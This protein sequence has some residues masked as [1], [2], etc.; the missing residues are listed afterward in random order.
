[1]ELS[2]PWD[3]AVTGDAEKVTP[4]NSDEWADFWGAI[5]TSGDTGDEDRGVLRNYL[6]ELEVIGATLPVTM[7]SGG[8]LVRG[9]L[10][11]NDDP[12]RFY[13]GLPTTATRTDR[14]VLRSSWSAQTIRAVL[15]ENAS[16]GTGTPPALTQS[17]GVTWE[18][19]IAT[20][21]VTTGGDVTVTDNRSWIHVGHH[22]QR[23]EFVRAMGGY[24][25]TN[26]T[27]LTPGDRDGVLLVDGTRSSAYS[28]WAVP[29]DYVKDLR[30]E[31]ILV[32]TA[33]VTGGTGN[34]YGEITVVHTACGENPNDGSDPITTDSGLQ[35]MIVT[36]NDLGELFVPISIWVPNAAVGDIIQ[37]WFWRFDEYGD[38][39]LVGDVRCMGFRITYT[40]D[41]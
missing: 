41:Y 38:G 19:P 9:R 12:V 21:A 37:L 35:T 31:P 40:S 13:V 3:G 10:Y 24:D 1:V 2:V 11:L 4:I 8:A 33:N 6:N 30:V 17:L 7:K 36:T 14:I 27:A 39:T 20:L 28:Q 34:L 5:F 32:T 15:S 25:Q 16:E 22:R 26:T 29:A 18:I 23:V